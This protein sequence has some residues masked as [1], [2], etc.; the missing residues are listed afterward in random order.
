MRVRAHD[1]RD[2][3]IEEP[4]ERVLLARGLAVHVHEDDICFLAHPGDGLLHHGEGI[5]QEHLHEGAALH[6]D[7]SHFS[8]RGVQHDASL[9]RR[10]VRIIDGAQ[11]ARLLGEPRRD[12]LLVP[13]VIA[14]SD[15]RRA[16]AHESNRE[17]GSDAAATGGV[18]AI[19]DGEVD[20]ELLLQFWEQ[21]VH[22][23]PPGVAHDIPE[24]QDANHMFFGSGGER[25]HGKALSR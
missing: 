18:F 12:F 19:D 4:T 22:R 5:F 6:I 10:I 21:V 7:D 11:H 17:L 9:P 15:D 20:G 8:L 16:R 24:E 25:G 13:D 2:A 14:G 3:P 1:G 23:A